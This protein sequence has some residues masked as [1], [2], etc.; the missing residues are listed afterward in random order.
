MC[1]FLWHVK[2]Y[3]STYHTWPDTLHICSCP[4]HVKSSGI[5]SPS[6]NNNTQNPQPQSTQEFLSK[7]PT[8]RCRKE[9]GICGASVLKN[10]TWV[11]VHS[12]LVAGIPIL[13][14]SVH[15][16]DFMSNMQLLRSSTRPFRDNVFVG[17]GRFLVG[18][19]GSL[20][21]V[22]YTRQQRKSSHVWET[23]HTWKVFP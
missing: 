8:H 9:F 6:N 21:A 22:V 11:R 4:L 19:C 15:Y 10:Q 23:S 12:E 20:Y 3:G 16:C 13:D 7:S 14:S 18:G 2:P 17:V 1:N 5:I